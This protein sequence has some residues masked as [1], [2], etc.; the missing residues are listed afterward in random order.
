VATYPLS[1]A[2]PRDNSPDYS[3]MWLKSAEFAKSNKDR[4]SII[5]LVLWN[6]EQRMP[7]S[8]EAIH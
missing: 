7:S 8:S 6:E 4:V 2:K 5:E 3:Q 1:R